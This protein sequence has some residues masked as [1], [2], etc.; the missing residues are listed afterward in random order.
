VHR[1]GDRTY[2]AYRVVH[3]TDELS[4]SCFS[5][6]V[7]APLEGRMKMG[8]VA[9]LHKEDSTLKMVNNGLVGIWIPPFCSVVVLTT[10]EYKPKIFGEAE[11]VNLAYP[12][13]LI[14]REMNIPLKFGYRNTNA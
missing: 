9:A 3:Q 11:L 10:R 5:N 6:Q 7:Y 8:G 14:S 4:S 2:N 1:E 13:P 12:S